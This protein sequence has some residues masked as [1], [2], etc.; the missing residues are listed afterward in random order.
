MPDIRKF[1]LEN[2]KYV[3]VDNKF[4]LTKKKL[5]KFFKDIFK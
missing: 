1:I 2:H 4:T 5:N 3:D